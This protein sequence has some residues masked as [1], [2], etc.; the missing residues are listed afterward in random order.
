MQQEKNKFSFVFSIIFTA[1]FTP[2]LYILLGAFYNAI[3]YP[4]G[5]NIL[6]WVTIV[7]LAYS[8]SYIILCLISKCRKKPFPRFYNGWA[9]FSGL[10]SVT[11]LCLISSYNID[12]YLYVEVMGLLSGIYALFQIIYD[13]FIKRKK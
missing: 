8:I 5:L 1:I 13:I 3:D 11:V 7:I 2:I 4:I 12:D 10:L 9:L 6:I